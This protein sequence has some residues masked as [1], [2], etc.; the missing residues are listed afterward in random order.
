MRKERNKP[1]IGF[2]C[3]LTVVSLLAHL[4]S[5][6]PACWISSRTGRGTEILPVAYRPLLRVMSHERLLRIRS[7]RTDSYRGTTSS[8]PVEDGLLGWYVALWAR[9][10]AHWQY[11]VSS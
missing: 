3:T 7:Q 9:E 10:G 4:L 5:F 6:G 8:C 2:W 1:G 11:E